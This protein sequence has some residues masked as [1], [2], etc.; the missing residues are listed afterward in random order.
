MQD[1]LKILD[2]VAVPL[3]LT[4]EKA[5]ATAMWACIGTKFAARWGTLVVDLAV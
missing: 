3:D 4:D 5:I 1:A 2:E